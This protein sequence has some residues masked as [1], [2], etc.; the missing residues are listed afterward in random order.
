MSTILIEDSDTRK[1]YYKDVGYDIP[2][3]RSDIVAK[4]DD[5]MCQVENVNGS[6]ND[7]LNNLKRIIKNTKVGV[8]RKKATVAYL[9]ISAAHDSFYK[10]TYEA[11][12]EHYESLD[13]QARAGELN[14]Y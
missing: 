8:A 9:I 3:I 2:E 14:D 12:E 10:P 11:I 6:V 1:C 4:E 13:D 5:E 7:I